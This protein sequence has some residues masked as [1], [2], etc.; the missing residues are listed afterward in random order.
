[1]PGN[2]LTGEVTKGHLFEGVQEEL[3]NALDQRRAAVALKP[4]DEVVPIRRKKAAK[5]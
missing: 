3:T 2:D 4:S 5:Q 1:M